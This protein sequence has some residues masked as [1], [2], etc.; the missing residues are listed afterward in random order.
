MGRLREIITA[1]WAE[2]SMER[3][4]ALSYYTLLSIAV[5]PSRKSA[6]AC[7]DGRVGLELKRAWYDGVRRVI[8]GWIPIADRTG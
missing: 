8:G 2:R 1:F 5:R 6:C 4:A 7:A 3:A